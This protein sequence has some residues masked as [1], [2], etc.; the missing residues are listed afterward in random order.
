MTDLEYIL[1]KYPI[2]NDDWVYR[3]YDG[4]FQKLFGSKSVLICLDPWNRKFPEEA[5][6]VWSTQ[7]YKQFK[8]T[9]EGIPV[10]CRLY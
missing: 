6:K 4:Y 1:W 9:V 5:Y 10:I 3:T 7:P 8:T 2:R